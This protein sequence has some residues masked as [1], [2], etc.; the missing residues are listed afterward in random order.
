MA[1]DAPAV[2][3]E[4]RLDRAR[5]VV[6]KRFRS[7]HRGEADREWWA[8][9]L[10]AEYAPGLA[11]APL[12]ASLAARPPVIEMSWLPGE[13]LS[14]APLSPGQTEALAVALNRLWDSVP[15]AA[16]EQ[17]GAPLPN[18]VSLAHRVRTVLTPAGERPGGTPL[19][20][21]AYAAGSAWL[22][23]GG[24]DWVL[25]GGADVVLG[26]GDANLANFLWDG[27]RVRLVD[28]E[29]SGPSE[30]AFEL[31]VLTEHISAWSDRELDTETFVDRLGLPAAVLAR[32]REYR[33]LMALFWLIML[34]PGGPA[35]RRN[36]PGTLDR[37]AGRLLALLD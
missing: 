15:A 29:D 9:C 23:G 19:A 1:R 35:S 17:P 36:P 13:P 6:T 33:R 26:Q 24:L 34:L 27:E 10:L 2:T 20:R 7:W 32:L 16:V 18:P 12:R 37:Q 4:V 22:S 31:A 25:H 11:A 28:F 30:R 8:L 3:H 5:G 21:R 14:G